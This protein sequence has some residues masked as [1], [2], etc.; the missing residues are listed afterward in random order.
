[1]SDL[2]YKVDFDF[3][4]FPFWSGARDRMEDA[5]EEQKEEVKQRIMDYYFSDDENIPTDGEINDLV[6]FDCDDIF[7]PE[8]NKEEVEESSKPKDVTLSRKEGRKSKEQQLDEA[9]HGYDTITINV[10]KDT[11]KD[12]LFKRTK[13]FYACDGY[14]EDFWNEI[15]DYIVDNEMISPDHADPMYIIDNIAVNGEIYAKDECAEIYSEINDEYNGDIDA[16][17]EDN[18][19]NVFDDYVVLNFGY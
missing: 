19:Y 1:M 8:E 12:W 11:Y 4:S 3:D 17:I 16:W 18:G 7:F 6:W 14:S 10:D 15:I 5:T 2:Y 13:E 9:N